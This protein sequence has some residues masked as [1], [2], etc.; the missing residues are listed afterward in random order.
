MQINLSF[1]VPLA[2]IVGAIVYLVADQIGEN[3]PLEIEVVSDTVTTIDFQN[4]ESV[5]PL[6]RL[7][8]RAPI[9]ESKFTQPQVVEAIEITLEEKKNRLLALDENIQVDNEKF[10]LLIANYDQNLDDEITKQK[11][12]LALLKSEAYRSDLIE[13]FKIERALIK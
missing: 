12:S 3:D 10:N 8:G 2:I 6:S 11:L 7:E 4:E 13:K 1:F 5:M 9:L